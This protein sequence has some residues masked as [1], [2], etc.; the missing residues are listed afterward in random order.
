MKHQAQVQ[1]I[2]KVNKKGETYKILEI[3]INDLLI[4]EVYI[5]DSLN[6]IIEYVLSTLDKNI[7]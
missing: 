4:H 1:I 3:Y 6:Q 2:E 7:D 5:K